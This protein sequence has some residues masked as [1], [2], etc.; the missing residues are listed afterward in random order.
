M[1]ALVIKIDS[2][3]NK[4]IAELV[5]ALGGNVLA[6]NDEAY[7][8]LALGELMDMVKTNENVSRASIMKKL[9]RK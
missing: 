1:S 4:I 9:K 8:D 6:I 2:K 3:G 7:E 5:R